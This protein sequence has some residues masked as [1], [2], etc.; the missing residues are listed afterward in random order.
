MITKSYTFTTKEV[1]Q[2]EIWKLVSDVDN[3]QSWDKSVDE[4]NIE[5]DF[6]SGNSF[7]LKPKGAGRIRIY[8][9]EVIPNS[10]YRDITKFP[11]AKMYGEHW[12]ENSDEDLK[13]T[14]KLSIKGLFAPLW[15]IIVMKDIVKNLEN[16]IKT[17]LQTIKNAR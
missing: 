5:G 13:I 6:E 9:D 4:S 14:I 17:Q 15:Y 2:D 10:Y 8:L 7:L 12:Y 1:S 3:W 11:F 16:N